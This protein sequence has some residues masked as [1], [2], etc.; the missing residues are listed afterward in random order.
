MILPNNDQ[1]RRVMDELKDEPALTE[2]EYE[3]ITSNLRRTEFT[4]RQKEVV[5]RLMEKYQCD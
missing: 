2:W 4:D 5:A 3:F 1:C